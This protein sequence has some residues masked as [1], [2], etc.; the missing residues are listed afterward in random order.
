MNTKEALINSL[1][2]KYQYKSYLEIGT[3]RGYCFNEI[4]CDF[5][6][7]IEPDHFMIQQG[8]YLMTSDVYFEQYDHKFD[9]VFIDGLHHA[10]QVLMDLGNA[11]SRLNANGRIILHDMLP[12]SEETQRVPR[13]S[14]EWYGDCWKVGYL[15]Y[16]KYNLKLTL[17]NFD[18]GI[19]EIQLGK[20]SV[21][22]LLCDFVENLDK[23]KQIDYD[24]HFM[25]YR[26]SFGS[27]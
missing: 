2:D 26:D 6:I 10:D 5:K 3:Q 21:D 18:C 11:A 20:D 7:G 19:L 22:D 8:H 13:E 25:D 17:H 24:Q 9:I 14:L 15:L 16:D 4:K 23:L 1:I 27:D 12:T